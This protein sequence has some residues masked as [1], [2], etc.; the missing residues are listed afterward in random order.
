MGRDKVANVVL[1]VVTIVWALNFVADV[2]VPSYQP[3]PEINAPFMAIVG[4][5]F[6]TGG[7]ESGRGGNESSQNRET[8]NSNEEQP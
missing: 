5:I 6:A 3:S 8:E 1:V 7:R 4:I 2:L